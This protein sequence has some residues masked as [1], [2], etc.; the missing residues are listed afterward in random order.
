MRRKSNKID[1]RTKVIVRALF[2]VN[3]ILWLAYTIY[4]YFDMAVVNQNE[5]AADIAAFSVFVTAVL[6]F[7]SGWAL[8]NQQKQSFYL[9]LIVV[10]LNIVLTLLNLTDIIFVI[11][12]FLDIAILWM[13]MNIRNGYLLKP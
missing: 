12:F 11:A 7:A 9:A 5:T 6:M 3:A 8:G 10:I 2:F 13:L 1:S 4:V